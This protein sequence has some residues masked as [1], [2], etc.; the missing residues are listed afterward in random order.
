[1]NFRQ[2]TRLLC[3]T[4]IMSGTGGCAVIEAILVGLGE[5]AALPRFTYVTM[6]P[7]QNSPTEN[8]IH[9]YSAVVLDSGESATFNEYLPFPDR[10]TESPAITMSTTGLHVALE[11]SE[12]FFGGFDSWVRVLDRNLN[13]EY[14]ASDDMIGGDIVNHCDTTGPEFLADFGPQLAASINS[15]TFA[16]GTTG[17]VGWGEG[18]IIYGGFSG[19]LSPSSFVV[20]IFN[21]PSRFVIEPG[22]PGVLDLGPGLTENFIYMIYEKSGVAWQVVGC[23]LE[24]PTIPAH[25]APLHNLTLADGT[26]ALPQ[27]I[28][29]LDGVE[30]LDTNRNRATGSFVAEAVDGPYQN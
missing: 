6:E 29:L 14:F 11:F 19:W 25:P 20:F 21:D 4:F 22:V 15:G 26:G 5:A 27:G 3:A 2:Q 8:T 10:M 24:P 17:L 18:P 1:M 28:I 12:P 23:T 9:L 13:V 7:V 16:P 30:L